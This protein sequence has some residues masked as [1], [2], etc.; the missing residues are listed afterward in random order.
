VPCP[1]YSPC[2]LGIF[3][4][5]N[6]SKSLKRPNK[7]IPLGAFGAIATSLVL[8]TVILCLLGAVADRQTLKTNTLLFCD[9]AWPNRWVAIAGLLVVGIGAG[10]QLLAI[11]PGVL[12]DIAADSIVPLLG[13]LHF[14]RTN[15]N[16]LAVRG[17]VLSMLIAF[18][19]LF[20]PNLD[21]VATVVTSM[22]RMP[23]PP[24]W[25]TAHPCISLH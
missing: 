8:Y 13:R 11:A 15:S 4:G 20:A 19:F 21:L 3:Y 12:R 25:M 17:L 7:S 6:V 9:C 10:M 16:G 18:P 22:A 23:Q 14:E 5:T 1:A 24:A 2:F